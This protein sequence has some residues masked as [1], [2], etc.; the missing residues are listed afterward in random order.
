[1]SSEGTSTAPV[2]NGN[3]EIKANDQV[4]LGLKNQGNAELSQGHYIS[5]INFYS[6]ALKLTP[7]NAIILSNR[8]LAYIKVES[9][10]LAILDSANAIASDP[11]YA[12]GYYRRGTAQYA[13]N[14]YKLARKD[15][16][17]VCKL[18][19]KDR[20]ARMRLKETEKAVKAAAF[21]AAI[22]SDG[23]IPLSESYD[24]SNIAI[25]LSYDGPKLDDDLETDLFEQP[26]KLPIDFVMAAIERFK[27]QKLIHKRYVGRLL[28][29]LK[30]YF[31]TLPSLLQMATPDSGPDENTAPRITVCGDTHGQFYDV[32]NIFEINGYPS[33]TNPYLFNGDFVD[34]G[35]FSVEVILTYFLFK[36]AYPDSIYLLRGNHET[37][38]MTKIYG[39]E[40]EVKHKY[41]AKIYD[42]F[43]EVFGYIPLAAVINEKVFITHGGLSTEANVT[44]DDI[45]KIPRGC[46]PPESGLMSDLLWS[47]PQPF[48]GRSPSK[49]GVGY[50]FGP[51]I[52]EAFLKR[53]KLETL[54]RSHEVKEE[55]YLVEHGGKTITIFSAPN[56]C[57]SMGNKGAMIHIE[58]DSKP[59]FVQYEAVPHP[60]VKP[61]AYA[62]GMNSLFM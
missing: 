36:M 21:A 8:A 56:Y 46:E 31:E 35:S 20:D 10:G 32:M 61:M 58:N 40:G 52:T 48:N 11:N 33:P 37:R 38:N 15:F 22:L 45:K 42:L 16:R 9:H 27:D 29:T 57:D 2:A 5:A 6:Q 18:L 23:S 19:P 60:P 39:F 7:N 17:M 55:G 44:L 28:V 59:K 25:D 43:L 12:K 41:D 13:L 30:H 34:R 4:S 14:K 62:A 50:S 53:N 1:M 26:G 49:R 54:I 24:P 51:D 47:D 3:G